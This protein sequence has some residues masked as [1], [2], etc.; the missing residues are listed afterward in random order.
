MAIRWHARQVTGDKQHFLPASLIGGFGRVAAGRS[1]REAEVRWRRRDWQ[2]SRP[3]VAE[4][5]G[6]VNKMY[7]WVPKTWATWPD[8]PQ[9]ARPGACQGVG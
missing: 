4:N 7:L 8:A 2:Q 9:A 1:S 5:L 6:Y 3:A